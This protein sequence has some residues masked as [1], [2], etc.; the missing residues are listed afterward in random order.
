MNQITKPFFYII[1]DEVTGRYYSGS[2]HAKG[3]TKATLL[4]TYFTSS[5]VVKDL[6]SEGHKFVIRRVKEF[7]KPSMAIDY[8]YNH[9]KR[10][11]VSK[12]DDWLNHNLIKGIDTSTPEFKQRLSDVHTGRKHSDEAKANMSKSMTGKKL[13]PEHVEKII[14]MN[15]GRKHTD[16]AKR[17]ISEAGKGRP[18]AK[19]SSLK[20]VI[21]TLSNGKN[22]G[23]GRKGNRYWARFANKHIGSFGTPEEASA[24]YLDAKAIHVALLQCQLH[25]ELG[26]V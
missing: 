6:I 12:N 21:A 9:Q 16:E 15:T 10:V 11:N 26:G 7:A 14:A 8:E 23:Y 17:K 1:Q 22:K 13:S 5:K 2:R 20:G 18:K 3:V 4:D 25:A 19:V 24:C